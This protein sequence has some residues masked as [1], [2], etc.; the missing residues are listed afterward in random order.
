[1]LAGALRARSDAYAGIE[2]YGRAFADLEEALDLKPDDETIYADRG[3]VYSLKGEEDKA[4]ADYD[5][6]S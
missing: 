6:G 3:V 1:M 4:A 2:D 5:Q